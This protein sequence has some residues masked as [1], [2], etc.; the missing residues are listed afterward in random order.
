MKHRLDPFSLPNV[1]DSRYQLLVITVLTAAT[2]IFPVW[3]LFGIPNRAEHGFFTVLAVAG[4]VILVPTIYQLYPV[5]KRVRGGLR[6][7][8]AR[9]SEEIYADLQRM[10]TEAGL[11]RPLVFLWN[12]LNMA[13]TAVAFGIKRRRYLAFSGGLVV[14]YATDRSAFRAVLLH[15]MAHFRNGDVERTYLTMAVWWAFV[16]W[17]LY[18]MMLISADAGTFVEWLRQAGALLVFVFFMRNSVLR[19]REVYADLRAQTWDGP[20][21]GLRAVLKSLPRYRSG[22]AWLHAHPS[23]DVRL[24]LLDAPQDIFTR[25]ANWS[26][27]GCPPERPDRQQG[28][29]ESATACDAPRAES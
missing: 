2:I 29:C 28:P 6:R 5:L 27:G 12:P 13:R 11:T 10:S 4:I 22:R 8:T 1:T 23:P 15:E 18:A 19:S 26:G 21:G 20:N 3:T 16:A 14:T 25:V 24:Q 9:D 17:G 7:F